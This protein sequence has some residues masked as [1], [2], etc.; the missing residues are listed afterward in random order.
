MLQKL[1]TELLCVVMKY[2]TF[3]DLE[4]LY[5]I[6]ILEPIVRHHLLRHYR[7]HYQVS[8]LLRLF[9]TSLKR[10][11]KKLNRS[12]NDTSDDNDT[13]DRREDIANQLLE[14]ICHVVEKYPKYEHRTKFSD[15]LGILESTVVKR[16]LA[17]N[18]NNI[19]AQAENDYA[20]LC[21]DIRYKYLHTPSIRVL[22][23]PVSKINI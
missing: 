18:N 12:G 15:L 3:D 10:K 14:L 13:S 1:P 17:H 2:L 7:F 20:L 19:P 6:Q 9:E 8:S 16:I 5:K 22:H 11:N 23:D 4:E 21:L